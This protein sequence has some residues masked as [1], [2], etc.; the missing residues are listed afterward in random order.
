MSAVDPPLMRIDFVAFTE[1]RERLAHVGGDVVHHVEA[2]LI[3]Q[4]QAEL[5]VV[6]DVEQVDRPVVGLAAKLLQIVG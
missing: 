1:H 2:G 6:G 3:L 4:L 5:D